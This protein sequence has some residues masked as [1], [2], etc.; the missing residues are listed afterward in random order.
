MDGF[1][2]LTETGSSLLQISVVI[3]L[4][5]ILPYVMDS[6]S[7]L[8]RSVLYFFAAML[9]LRYLI[10]RTMFTIS[11]PELSWDCL[12]SWS[13]LGFEVAA[14]IC[15]FST[16]ALMSRTINRSAEADAHLSWWGEAPAPRVAVL[17]ATYN[18]ELEI[19][20]RTIIGAKALNHVNK[21][22]FVLDDG[23]RDWLRDYCE[24]QHVRYL[25]RPD[26]KGS[27]AGNINHALK[28]LAQELAPP[29]FFAV[30]D[31]DFV[32]H[33]GFISRSLALFHDP[34]VGLVQT[35]QHFFN[36][37]PVQHNLG[38]SQSYPDEQRF[39]FDHVQPARDAWG[40]A[41]CCGTSSV[42]R[43]DA[44]QTIGGFPTDSVT[45]DF[46]VT[47]VLQNMGWKTVYLN[48]PLTEGLAPEGLKEYVTQRARWCL[49]LMQ[50]ARS[51]VGPFAANNLRLRDRWSIIDSVF[52]WLFSFPFRLAA[53]IYPLLY[54]YFNVTSVT[55]SV[56]DV[57]S[58]FGVF[59]VW[60]MM[61]NFAV[62]RGMLVPVIHDVSQLLGAIP[63]TRAAVTGLFRPHGHPFS[64]TAK[65]GDRSKTVIQWRM[66]LPYLVL[67]I[68]TVF[69]LLLGSL[70]DG[71]A[72]YD[73]GEGKIVVL[74]WSLYNVVLLSVMMI[75][76][77]E[78]PRT[79]LHIADKPERSIF[80][81]D[82]RIKRIW[83]DGLTQD[84]LRIRGQDLQIGQV[85]Q[86]RIKNVGDVQ[87]TVIGRASD[88]AR[89]RLQTTVEQ[90]EAL[91]L[92]FYSE[93]DS[94][95]VVT[96]RMLAIGSDLLNRLAG[97]G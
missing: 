1:P 11:P 41:I 3:G 88:G 37:D 83:I 6:K 93:G 21:E 85:G 54:W 69:G 9:G 18:E 89:L 62:A 91:I 47:L 43:W 30:L 96:A 12:A 45:E 87:S 67:L 58:Y 38:L 19:L 80:V 16:F 28:V 86:I 40:M 15:A 26:N 51:H 39:F 27:K 84:T 36:A 25:R 97:S 14:M 5:M 78:L 59:F 2:Y 23:R 61:T 8:H 42:M 60:I 74:C 79:E 34:S 10:W 90:K 55:A 44:I 64:V 66:M 48:E 24:M 56:A 31:A 95:G 33:R 77:V 17:I 20:E 13:L 53:L 29:A 63:I 35:P 52:Y 50:I 81:V 72:Y 57:L 46:M 92:R 71:Y 65:G 76:F 75:T 70:S 82:G 94:P 68:L 73:A 4:A 32:P 22:V 7:T 49:G